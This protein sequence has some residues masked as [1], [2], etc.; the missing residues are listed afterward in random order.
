MKLVAICALS[1]AF[2]L[3]SASALAQSGLYVYPQKGQDKEQ[4]DRD[5]YECY[6]WAKQNS[7]VDPSAPSAGRDR[8]RRA[9]G[10]VRGAAGGAALGAGIG[11]IAGNAGKGAAIGAAAGGVR[12]RRGAMQAEQRDQAAT[13]NSY[14]RAY[15]ACMEGRGYTVR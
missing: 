11:A 13:R 5:E 14:D 2:A 3:A 4:Q 8:G 9:G 12:G 15:A 6:R 1:C 7:G 10:T